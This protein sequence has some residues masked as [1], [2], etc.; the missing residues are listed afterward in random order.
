[1]DFI[2]KK[3]EKKLEKYTG[4]A[5]HVVIPAGIVEIGELAFSDCQG[6][7]SVVIPGGVTTIGR[8]AF[9]GCGNL[10]KVEMPDSVTTLGDSCFCSCESLAEITLSAGLTV[11]PEYCFRQCNSLTEID[12]PEGVEELGENAFCCCE[13]LVRVG[14]PEG[15][16][17]IGKNAFAGCRQ[18]SE[19]RVPGSVTEIGEDAFLHCDKLSSDSVKPQ[20]AAFYTVVTSNSPAGMITIG[21]EHVAKRGYDDADCR[22]ILAEA[23]GYVIRR[24]NR[25]SRSGWYTDQELERDNTERVDD[26]KEEQ[27]LVKDGHFCGCVLTCRSSYRSYSCS[28]TKEEPVLLTLGDTDGVRVEYID[29]CSDNEDYTSETVARLE[30]RAQR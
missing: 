22:R 11:I 15:L 27:I 16:V 2:I 9:D 28:S 19:I 8:W 12:I 29:H 13:N 21:E 10:E 23:A 1:M 20:K 5:K 17:V 18:L 24:S 4:R 25:A 14:L 26:V 30:K 3:K 6:V 7:R